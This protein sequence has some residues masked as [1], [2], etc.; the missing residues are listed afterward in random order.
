MVQ[1]QFGE[2]WHMV[3]YQLRFGTSFQLVQD[4]FS[5]RIFKYLVYGTNTDITR[6]SY[7]VFP[8]TNLTASY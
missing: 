8:T 2:A 7:S 6:Q 3:K 1:Q 5:K 4:Q